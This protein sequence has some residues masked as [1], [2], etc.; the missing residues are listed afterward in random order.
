MTIYEVCVMVVLLVCVMLCC[1]FLLLFEKDTLPS[2]GRRRKQE[3]LLK[4]AM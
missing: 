3:A 1:A 4:M 2:L